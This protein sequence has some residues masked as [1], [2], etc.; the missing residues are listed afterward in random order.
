MYILEIVVY[1]V[2]LIWTIAPAITVF[3]CYKLAQLR[4]LSH[5]PP[6]QWP[7]LSIIIPACNEGSTIATPLREIMD[8]D[9]PNL[10]VIVINDRSSDNT[11]D[12][13]LSV[14][15]DFP[16]LKYLHIDHLPEDWLGKVHALHKGLELATGEW[17]LFTDAD[18]YIHPKAMQRIISLCVAEK[19]D[20]FSLLPLIYSRSFLASCCICTALRAIALSQRPWNANDPDSD[21]AVGAGAFNLVRKSFFMHHTK[22]FE[23]L[24][25][26]VAD[27]LALGHMMK[28]SGGKSYVVLAPED[29]QVEWYPSLSKAIRGL[30][31]NAFAQIARFSLWRGMLISLMML[32]LGSLP[33][34]APLFPWITPI[35]IISPILCGYLLSKYLH[36]SFWSVFASFVLGELLLSYTLFRSTLLGIKR[37]GVIWRGTVYPTAKLREGCRL[38]F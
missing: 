28:K 29:V 21:S 2:A 25:M 5:P 15:H 3:L 20:H 38:D 24:R 33:F 32:L 13:I 7:K 11:E 18:I 9:Y 26:E 23:W 19:I 1:A 4:S 14:Q 30:E 8:M 35:V 27:D 36:L 16:S 22:G 31:K 6:V 12:E 34:F 17:V 37:G 10:E